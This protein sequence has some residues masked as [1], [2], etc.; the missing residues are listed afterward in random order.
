MDMELLLLCI[1]IF[2]VR[3]MD[4]SLG[5]IRTVMTVRGKNTIAALIGFV[6]VTIWFLVVKDA[7]NSASN[8]L[9]IAVSYAGGF[10]TGTF[11]GGFISKKFIR[12]KLGVQIV[13]HE[14]KKAVV[15][16]LRE[17]G[18]A[19]STVK[20]QGLE[21][22]NKLMLFSEIDSHHLEDLKDIVKQYDEKAFIVVN[23][24]KY[25]QNGYFR[26]VAK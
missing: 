15:N 10:A 3:I 20:A 5:T 24:T 6:E 23:E 22:N 19:L 1:R 21:G 17:Q 9:W 13:I 8:S 11:I 16:A 14:E 4:V 12:S 7:L 2:I 26:G 18:Y 25:V